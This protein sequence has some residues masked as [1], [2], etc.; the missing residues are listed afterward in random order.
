MTVLLFTFSAFV[1][2]V[3]DGSAQGKQWNTSR[4]PRGHEH[5]LSTICTHLCDVVEMA[6]KSANPTAAQQNANKRTLSYG[7]FYFWRSTDASKAAN[8]SW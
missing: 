8:T 5:I 7:L 1:D 4:S 2:P 3:I 6:V